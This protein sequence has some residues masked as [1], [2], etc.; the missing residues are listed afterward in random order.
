MLE[1]P[2]PSRGARTPPCMSTGTVAALSDCASRAQERGETSA[3]ARKK[4]ECV[5]PRTRME[6]DGE[7]N[8]LR[9][10]S[11]NI[12]QKDVARP[13]S[14]GDF[15]MSETGK[16][17]LQDTHAQTVRQLTHVIKISSPE[18]KCRIVSPK[19]HTPH[20]TQHRPNPKAS[21]LKPNMFTEKLKAV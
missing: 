12:K 18:F 21:T 19:P 16:D 1:H 11:H 15:M 10:T 2:R 6:P 4:R 9:T 8:S 7:T 20:P 17:A 13:E 5:T 14:T 3:R